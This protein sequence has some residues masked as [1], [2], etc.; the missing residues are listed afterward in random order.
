[1]IASICILAI[2]T[3]LFVYWF[4]YTCMLI[5]NTQTSTDYAGEV[6][7]ANELSFLEVQSAIPS[8]GRGHLVAIHNLLDRDYDMVSRLLEKSLGVGDEGSTIEQAMLRI[9]FLAMKVVFHLSRPVSDR[10]A[11]R[12]LTEM[13][14]VVAHLANSFGEQRFVQ[15]RS[16]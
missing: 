12:S 7:A 5:L 9:D 14:H 4:R 10:L 1:M 2:S 11:R 3:G 15:E 16:F 13:T 6:A 8:A